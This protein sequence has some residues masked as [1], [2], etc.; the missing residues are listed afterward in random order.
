MGRIDT[1]YRF[2]VHVKRIPVTSIPEKDEEITK[3]A[4][5]LYKEKNDFLEEMKHNWT[6]NIQ[7]IDPYSTPDNLKTMEEKKDD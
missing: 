6:K 7:L 1:G 2:H 3:W 4:V 5:Q